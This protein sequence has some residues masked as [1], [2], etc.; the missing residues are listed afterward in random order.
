MTNERG[1][2][3]SKLEDT[4][5]TLTLGE[6]WCGLHVACGFTV[7]HR[8]ALSMLIL[9]FTWKWGF[10]HIMN[11]LFRTFFF[12]IISVNVVQSNAAVSF[13]MEITIYMYD[14]LWWWGICN[15]HYI[16][17]EDLPVLLVTAL[18]TAVF[19]RMN[20]L[21]AWLLIYQYANLFI[22]YASMKNALLCWDM[23]LVV[24]LVL[25]DMDYW[26]F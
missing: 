5:F 1:N 12:S 10:L 23:P 20:D 11:Q 24:S 19:T 18:Y 14:L 16:C 15:S 8:T 2:V 22:L 3:S 7:F 9:Q 4:Y 21:W 13:G 26:T 25:S 17:H 6:T